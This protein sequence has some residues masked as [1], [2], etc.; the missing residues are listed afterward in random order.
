MNGSLEPEDRILEEPTITEQLSKLIST[1]GWEVDD[2]VIVELAGTQVSGIDVGEV[3]NKKWQSPIGTRKYNKDAFIIIS[4]QSR[5][6][7]SKS[8]PQTEFKPHHTLNTTEEVE[9]NDDVSGVHAG[10]VPESNPSE[11]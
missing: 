4:N 11:G 10:V 6:D 2:D 5:R 8:L 9:S 3:Y 1:L 7:L